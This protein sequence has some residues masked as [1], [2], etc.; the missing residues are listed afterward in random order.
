MAKFVRKKSAKK[1]VLENFQD[2]DDKWMVLFHSKDNT[3]NKRL[4]ALESKF[5]RELLH[6]KSPSFRVVV[7]D[8]E[9][10]HLFFL[11]SFVYFFRF[12]MPSA[13]Q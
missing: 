12:I 10:F 11:C 8:K 9:H 2:G 3:N 6:T 13:L 4:A 5:P 1:N 7:A